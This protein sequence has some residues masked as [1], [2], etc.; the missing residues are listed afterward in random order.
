MD[1]A[2]IF[3]F[4]SIIIVGGLLFAVISLTKRG[5]SF[6]DQDRY[7]SKWL[8]IEQQLQRDQP[9]SFHLSVLNADKLLD[10]ALRERGLRGQTMAERMKSG[11]QMFSNRNNVW[12]AHKLRNQIAHEPDVHVTYDIAKQALAGFKQA[13]KDVGAL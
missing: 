1:Q 5:R 10:Q 4:A 12:T 3:M 9:A 13:L 11:A 6:L 2:V 8:A 7:R